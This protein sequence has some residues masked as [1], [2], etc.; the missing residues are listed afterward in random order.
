VGLHVVSF[1]N[2]NQIEPTLTY[3]FLYDFYAVIVDD[4][5]FVSF[6]NYLFAFSGT[7]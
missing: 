6:V 5:N 1:V 3:L 2:Y 4:D 7:P